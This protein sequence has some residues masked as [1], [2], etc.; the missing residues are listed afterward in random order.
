M[1]CFRCCLLRVLERARFARKLAF[2][3][4]M[5]K[6]ATV[7]RV[8][9]I[10]AADSVLLGHNTDLRLADIGLIYGASHPVAAVEAAWRRPTYV[11]L[12]GHD[13]THFWRRA[14]WSALPA[15]LRVTVFE[16]SDG[17]VA[18]RGWPTPEPNA[19]HVHDAT[20]WIDDPRVR[21]LFVSNPASFHP[22]LAAYPRALFDTRRWEAAL[23]GSV[24]QPRRARSKL[25]FCNCM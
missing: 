16:M 12:Q 9:G 5:L 11:S 15:D 14:N 25:L 4:G 17:S 10:D 22:K 7:G 21:A 19:R 3:Q 8:N 1:R 6:N 2:W 20:T 23:R 24:A 13:Q 18:A